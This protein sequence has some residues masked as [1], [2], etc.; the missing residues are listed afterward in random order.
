M[1]A[2]FILKSDTDQQVCDPCRVHWGNTSL[3]TARRERDHRIWW[4]ERLTIV[5]NELLNQKIATEHQVANLVADARNTEQHLR[6]QIENLHH[7]IDHVTRGHV[8]EDSRA[9]IE[10]E[11]VRAS[12]DDRNRAYRSRGRANSVLW[13]LL[14]MHNESESDPRTCICGESTAKCQ[15]WQALSDIEPG[16]SQWENRQIERLNKQLAH[17]LPDSHPDVQRTGLDSHWQHQ[18]FGHLPEL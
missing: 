8:S 5:E 11:T 9:R 17:E 15:E 16:I 2:E 14:Q 13:E 12:Y 3:K 7:E 4:S 6:G 1:T 10:S 18:H